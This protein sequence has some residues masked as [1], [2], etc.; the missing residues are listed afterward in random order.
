MWDQREQGCYFCLCS[1][2]I[3][4]YVQKLG[5]KLNKFNQY[6]S[7]TWYLLNGQR[8]RASEV[9]ANPG[10]LGYPLRPS[11][12]N[13]TVTDLFYQAITKVPAA[14]P[15]RDQEGKGWC[16]RLHSKSVCGFRSPDCH[17]ILLGLLPLLLTPVK[18]VTTT[19]LSALLFCL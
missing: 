10:I 13:K 4:T 3:H 18:V 1:R 12:K 6:D 15:C 11:E 2:L 14:F 16:L 5:L 8:Y 9:M 17:P 19:P 7:N